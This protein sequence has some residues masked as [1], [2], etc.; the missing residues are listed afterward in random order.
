MDDVLAQF[1]SITS[2]DPERA[3]QYLRVTDNNLEQAI[4]LYFESDGVDMGGSLNPPAASAVPVSTAAA[5]EP[6]PPPI[7]L[8]SDDEE[9]GERPPHG[10]D[11]DEAMA[12]RLQD[13]M[14]GS[15]GPNRETMDQED[16]RAP[17]GRTTETLLGPGA[18][19][20]EDPDE[21]RA[22]IAEQMVAR[23][24]R[25]CKSLL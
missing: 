10:L 18:D 16:V 1:T 15:S 19:W 7:N 23:Q 14:Y 22:A 21:M 13:E 11:N 25:R 4:Q 9:V 20:R 8:D 2:A 17:M 24:Q 6:H 5:A 12:R 3:S